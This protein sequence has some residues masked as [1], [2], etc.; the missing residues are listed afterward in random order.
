MGPSNRWHWNNWLAIR[1]QF[2]LHASYQNNFHMVQRFNI[3]I[4]IIKIL[5][6]NVCE[7]IDN[8]RLRK[9]F[10]NRPQNLVAVE[11]KMDKVR[12]IKIRSFYGQTYQ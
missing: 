9:A 5:Q 8:Q 7:F 1:E 12:A 10:G 4:K 3:K 2:L 11:E 6:E